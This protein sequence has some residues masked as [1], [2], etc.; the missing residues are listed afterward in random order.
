MFQ[1]RKNV[2]K[3]VV[4]VVLIIT[5]TIYRYRDMSDLSVNSA[6]GGSFAYLVVEKYF[7]IFAAPSLRKQEDIRHNRALFGIFSD[8]ASNVARRMNK[9]ARSVL[10]LG[11]WNAWKT[12]MAEYSAS[13]SAG[14]KNAIIASA[15]ILKEWRAAIRTTYYS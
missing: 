1:T 13:I 6:A 3:A 10:N 4:L 8:S 15:D 7:D 9:D 2:W 5:S 14:G 12:Y 11:A